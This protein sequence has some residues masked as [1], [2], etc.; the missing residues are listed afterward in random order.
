MNDSGPLATNAKIRRWLSK[1]RSAWM[2]AAFALVLVIGLSVGLVVPGS[3]APNTSAQ[4]NTTSS[5]GFGSNARSA[6]AAGGA[7]GAINDVSSSGMTFTTSAGQTVTVT[8]SNATKYK[9]GSH[10]TSSTSL[11]VGDDVLVFGITNSATIGVTEI[12]VEP[13]GSRMFK[14]SSTVIPFT[15]GTSTDSREVGAIPANWSQGSG[16]IV[17]ATS[18]DEATT[19]ALTKYPGGVVD[20]VVKLGNGQYNVHYIGVNWP[21]HVF[22]SQNFKVVGAE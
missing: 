22:V 1:R 7:A 21:H 9:R 19:A 4:S 12:I 13:A 2:V 17:R 20:R 8:Y 14:A 10:S 15:R 3:S 11:K 18:A 16:A 5:G 6:P